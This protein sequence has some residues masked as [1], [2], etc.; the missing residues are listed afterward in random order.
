M[1]L[2]PLGRQVLAEFLGTSLLLVAVVGTSSMSAALS[3]DDAGLRLLQNS[4]AIALA[5]TAIIYA[6]G[7][8]SRAHF[9]P[10]VSVA[11]W[12]LGRGTGAGLTAKELAWYICA[13]L[14][15]GFSGTV[16][17][18]L[19]VDRP[20][21]SI[22]TT[23]RTG[24]PLL[25]SE[26]VATSGLLIL[27]AALV[28]TGRSTAGPGALGAYVGAACWF[29]SSACFANP[30]VTLGRTFT[31]AD[32]GIAPASLPGFLLAQALGLAVACALIP[33]LYPRTLA[34]AH[35]PD[36]GATSSKQVPGMTDGRLNRSSPPRRRGGDVATEHLPR[37]PKQR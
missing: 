12:F 24:R 15:G 26:V 22:A 34:K 33:I 2:R 25:L 17:A 36:L 29:T 3:P 30:A 6:F 8:A 14:A 5:L 13:Q 31:S 27:I 1:A 28:R 11:D 35:E 19:M 23:A 16:L 18:D 7:P 21:V 9:N 10:V 20:A 4:S 37:L 32:A